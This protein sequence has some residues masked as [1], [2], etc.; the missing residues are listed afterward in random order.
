MDRSIVALRLQREY[1]YTLIVTPDRLIECAGL[2]IHSWRGVDGCM[3][4]S[5]IQ[6]CISR[7]RFVTAAVRIP[8]AAAP[9]QRRVEDESGLFSQE[10]LTCTYPDAVSSI[11]APRLFGNKEAP[12]VDPTPR[13]TP[14]EEVCPACCV[15]LRW[16]NRRGIYRY[17]QLLAFRRTAPS[18]SLST[19]LRC[20]QFFGL[21]VSFPIFASFSSS[22]TLLPSPHHRSL[23]ATK[24]GTRHSHSHLVHQKHITK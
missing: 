16:V 1:T 6:I 20:C 12:A 19:P 18:P 14:A 4:G 5:D 8:S 3:D 10:E 7:R 13:A 9:W 24:E 23:C 17:S 2:T 21:V 15:A 11:R 22:S